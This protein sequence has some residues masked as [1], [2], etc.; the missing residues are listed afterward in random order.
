MCQSDRMRTRPGRCTA[1][2]LYRADLLRERTSQSRDRARAAARGCAATADDRASALRRTGAGDP[3][4]LPEPA[5]SQAAMAAALHRV[6]RDLIALVGMV[7]H[8]LAGQIR[9]EWRGGDAG[10]TPRR[11]IP[12]T[13]DAWTCTAGE[14]HE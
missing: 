14:Q 12:A 4:E 1:L 5:A 3:L 8:A 7:D 11:T 6:R 9:A 10:V 13:A 2:T